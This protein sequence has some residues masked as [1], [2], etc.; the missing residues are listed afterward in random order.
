AVHYPRLAN[1]LEDSHI[2][3]VDLDPATNRRMIL[4]NPVSKAEDE[5]NRD[6]STVGHGTV[7]TY[8]SNR[9]RANPYHPRR[10]HHVEGRRY[11]ERS[12]EPPR[13][14]RWCR[15]RNTSGSWAAASTGMSR[16]GRLRNWGR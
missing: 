10:H 14:R 12:P 5:C 4:S 6:V 9:E 15:R 2:A 16:V 11:G 3:S 8:T 13:P 1:F 7:L